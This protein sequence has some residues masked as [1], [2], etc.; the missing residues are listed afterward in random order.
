MAQH[1]LLS[2]QARTLT[3]RQ[4]LAVSE[5]EAYERFKALR[6]PATNG[7]PVCPACG[8]LKHWTLVEN[9]K[10][11]CQDTSCRVQFTVTSRTILAS[12]KMSFRDLLAA[13]AITVNGVLGTAALRMCR[14]MGFAYKTAFVLAHKL[15][16]AMSVDYDQPLEGVVEIDGAYVGSK[17]H[18][19]PNRRVEGDETFAEWLK[20]NPKKQTSLVAIRERGDP[21]D[22][23]RR[24]KVRAFHVPKE[25]DAIPTARR[26]VKEGTIVHADEGTQ[27]EPMEMYFEMKRINHSESYSDGIA[28]TNGVESAFSRFRCGERGVYR[29]VT[30]AYVERYGWEMAWREEMRRVPNGEQATTLIGYALRSKTSRMA[31]YWQRHRP[32]N[33]LLSPIAA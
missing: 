28:C 16:E 31:G 21:N 9:R 27:W 32:A 23:E 10:W 22:P 4:V 13:I 2:P 33:D 25:G 1:F 30:K 29:Y 19:F 17:K 3:L 20:K 18:R 12:R 7:A 26:I 6:W 24:P 14:E 5:E 11:K 15:R 8:G